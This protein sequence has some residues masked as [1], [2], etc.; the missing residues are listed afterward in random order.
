MIQDA[1]WRIATWEEKRLDARWHRAAT[2]D[3]A[4]PAISGLGH[5]LDVVLELANVDAGDHGSKL[6]RGLEHRNGSRGNLDWRARP[7]IT[8]HARLAVTY[9]ERAEPA[10]F[11]VLL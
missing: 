10:H 2:V 5:L 8:S 3:L 9:L 7:W 4:P 1:T 11:D 6:L